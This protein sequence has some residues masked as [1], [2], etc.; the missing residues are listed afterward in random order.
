MKQLI[1]GFGVLMLLVC[2][3]VIIGCNEQIETPKEK[4][5]TTPEQLAQLLKSNVKP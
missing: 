4:V 5:I 3:L 2:C 1:F